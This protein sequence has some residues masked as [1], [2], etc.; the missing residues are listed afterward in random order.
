M[1][2]KPPIPKCKN[3]DCQCDL[4]P[5]R[6]WFYDRRKKYCDVCAKERK[7]DKDAQR[8]KAK[9]EQAKLERDREIARLR[10]ENEAFQKQH[11]HDVI[12]N[13]SLQNR[14]AQLR[15]WGGDF[16]NGE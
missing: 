3:K 11:E 12:V 14:L 1:K 8:M 6:R 4:Y 10:S 5:E 7:R 9:R 15:D 16:G 2:E 13:Q